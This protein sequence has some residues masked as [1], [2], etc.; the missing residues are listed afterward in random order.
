M[1][2]K[3]SEEEMWEEV[4]KILREGISNLLRRIKWVVL[5]E[6]YLATRK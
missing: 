5:T 6:F 1:V 3:M 4:N 2:K